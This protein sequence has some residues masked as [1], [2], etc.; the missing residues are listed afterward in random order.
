MFGIF[1]GFACLLDQLQLNLRARNM[2]GCVGIGLAIHDVIWPRNIVG[3]M[4]IGL[5]D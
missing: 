3:C 1:G 2:I 4:D 5:D